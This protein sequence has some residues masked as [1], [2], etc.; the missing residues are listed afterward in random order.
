M[1]NDV[2]EDFGVHAC[3]VGHKDKKPLLGRRM[4]N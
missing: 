1:L 2:P 4:E 3:D